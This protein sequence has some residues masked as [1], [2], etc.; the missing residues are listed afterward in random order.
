MV[1]F[2]GPW[3]RSQISALPIPPLLGLTLIVEHPMTG[4]L[5]VYLCDP[6]RL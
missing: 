5:D 4:L 1:L 3:T 6:L 2:K